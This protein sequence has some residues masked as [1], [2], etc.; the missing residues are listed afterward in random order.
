MLYAPVKHQFT[1]LY[2]G[3]SSGPEAWTPCLNSVCSSAVC[4][5]SPTNGGSVANSVTEVLSGTASRLQSQAVR[6]NG[7]Y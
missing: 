1:S 2:H 3:P 7:M 4:E 6:E 5:H